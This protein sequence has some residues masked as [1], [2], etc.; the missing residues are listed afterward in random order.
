MRGID[1]DSEWTSLLVGFLLAGA[2]AGLVNPTLAEAAIGVVPH[3]RAGVATGI[4]NTFRQ[5]G[6]AVGIAVLGA[7]FS[8]LNTIL[9]VAA[10]V[11]F[12]GA[13]LSF[14]LVRSRDF[15][16]HELEQ[17]SEERTLDLAA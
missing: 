17:A 16:H 4:N 1:A 10:A 12:A 8:G 15:G 14:L 5:V 9:L 6:I 11:A 7:L 3:E 2:G 13:V